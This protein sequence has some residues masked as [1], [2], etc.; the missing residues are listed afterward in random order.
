MSAP[1]HC[2]VIKISDQIED[3]YIVLRGAVQSSIRYK[4]KFAKL[5]VLAPMM[6]FCCNTLINQKPAILDYTTC[7]RVILMQIPAVALKHFKENKTELWYK[8]ND[9]IAKS[10]AALE[11]AAN[12]LDIRLHG[13]LYNRG[14]DHV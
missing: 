11:Q 6:F 10:F 5:S 9:M 2:P 12:R 4:N 3:T 1:N 14:E 8:L 7:E 13:E